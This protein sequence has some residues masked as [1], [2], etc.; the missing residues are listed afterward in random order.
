MDKPLVRRNQFEL[1]D[2]FLRQLGALIGA[3]ETTIEPTLTV[4]V[5]GVIKA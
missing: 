2:Q 4:L 3:R 5:E 1:R